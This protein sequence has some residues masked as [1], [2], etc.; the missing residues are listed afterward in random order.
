MRKTQ[1]TKLDQQLTLVDQSQLERKQH[2]EEEL[3]QVEYLENEN[4]SLQKELV[5]TLE[6]KRNV[7]GDTEKENFDFQHKF[8]AKASEKH[9]LRSQ[10][11]EVE[12]LI[13]Q[14][15]HEI[16]QT[17]VD[18]KRVQLLTEKEDE[19]L[20]KKSGEEKRVVKLVQEDLKEQVKATEEQLNLAQTTQL[21]QEAIEKNLK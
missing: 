5:R 18:N 19:L 20:Q 2:T 17:S 14:L 10:I 4:L 3:D 16:E 13:R 11:C 1:F 9:S 15:K 7:L 21:K 12:H 6:G 8:Q